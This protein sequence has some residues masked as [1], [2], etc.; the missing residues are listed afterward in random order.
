MFV[1]HPRIVESHHVSNR[2][3]F[4]FRKQSHASMTSR[5]N[6]CQVPRVL[7]LALTSTPSLLWLQWIFLTLPG[8][9]LKY[10]L[11]ATAASQQY[12]Y[13]APLAANQ[14]FLAPAQLPVVPQQ[15]YAMDMAEPAFIPVAVAPETG[16]S[17]STLLGAGLLGAAVAGA[18]VSML[19][20]V[21]SLIS[22]ELEWILL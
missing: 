8:M 7:F 2:R 20:Y 11:A 21:F 14:A 1:G 17:S 4:L 22:S 12:L 9:P 3:D 5:K 16:S 6:R 15:G 13:Q 19:A 10:A 18:A